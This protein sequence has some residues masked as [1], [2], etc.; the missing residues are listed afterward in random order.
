VKRIQ[1]GSSSSSPQDVLY[2]LPQLK[3]TRLERNYIKSRMKKYGRCSKYFFPQYLKSMKIT[4]S[5]KAG[6]AM[7][8]LDLTI[9]VVDV[10]NLLDKFLGL[11]PA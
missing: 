7:S 11:T 4:F 5:L 1:T 8:D 6:T 10:R 3:I 9:G 2:T